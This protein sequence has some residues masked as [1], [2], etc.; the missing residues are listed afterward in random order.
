MKSKLLAL[1]VAASVASLSANAAVEGSWNV[2]AAAGWVHSY[3]HNFNDGFNISDKNG[4]GVKLSGEYNFTD[5]FAL[6][7]AYDYING[8]K[9]AL[10]NWESKVHSNVGEFY[11]RFALPLDSY[12]SDLFFKA[13][14]TWTRTSYDGD[15]TSKVGAVV[16]L[17][18]QWA[19]TNNFALRAGYDYFIKSAKFDNGAKI[20]NGLLYIGASYIFGAEPAAVVAAPQPAEKKTVRVTENHSLS[21]GL[22]FPFN[23]STLSAEG[24][25]AVADVVASSNNLQNTEY[26]VYGYTDRI[27][28]DAYNNKLSQKR[29]DAVAQALQ[30]NG[31]NNLAATE[32]RGKASPV[33]G[34]K[35]DSV[36]GRKAVI[37]CLA[38][39]RRVEIV[40]TGDTV[41]EELQ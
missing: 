10:G 35:C 21:A 17:G 12:G 40:V 18:G 38:P 19:V 27:G 41:K 8:T 1:A 33:T 9:I 11:G 39:D 7:A 6:G 32:G 4:Y 29:A 20:N 34:N 37:D 31:V 16:G 26:A 15:H 13:G 24:K 25:K 23:G 28:S 5:W 14:P 3:E 22:L 36:K 30:D 2:G